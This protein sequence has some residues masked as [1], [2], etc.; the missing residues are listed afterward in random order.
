[1]PAEVET[2]VLIV[3]AGVAGALLA[4]KLAQDGVKVTI[5]EAGG[6][7]DR[8][9]AVQR[10]L[11]AVAMVPEAPYAPQ[12]WAPSPNSVDIGQY[13]IQEGPQP[14]KST[15]ERRV[16]G[17]TWHW[18]GTALR[19]VPAD[20]EL[21]KRY[22][23]GADWPIGYADLEPWY[24]EAEKSLGVSGDS[25]QDL[26]SPRKT[27]YPMP[28]IPQTTVDAA[29][30][31]AAR[32]LQLVVAP[33]PQAR[34]AQE[35]DGRPQCCGN[36]F[37]IPICPI[38]AKYDASA[39]VAQAEKAGVQVLAESVAFRV[40]IDS[41][42]RVTGVRFKKPDN[43][44]HLATARTYVVA[45]HAVETPRLLLMS[46]PKGVANSSDQVG[47]NLCDHPTQL[48]WALAA[49]P[50][51]PYRS[52]LATSGIEQL[53]DGA[54]RTSRGAF[55]VEIGNDG[56]SWPGM[57]PNGLVDSLIRQGLTGTALRER[58]DDNASRQFRFAS[59]VEQ[60]P[61]P[62][63]R[64]TLDSQLD[65]LGLPRPRIHYDVDGYT[66]AG[67]AEAQRLHDRLFDAM[68]ATDRAHSPAFEGAGHIIGTCRMGADPK[69]SV[70]DANSRTHDHAN[71][72]IIGSSVFP[73]TGTANPT[74]TIAAL[75]LRSAA[76][77]KATLQS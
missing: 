66:R 74:L 39:H 70:V 25:Q 61:D 27:P 71:L 59:L 20:F 72:F 38:G 53:R 43:S 75:A 16:G 19:L 9:A 46:S 77:V 14:F 15:Y 60:L 11:A 24:G 58:I 34:N 29:V 5:L 55:R 76:A 42:G 7:V 57:D 21:R 68:K 50:I 65:A 48:S 4:C 35:Y 73:S 62:Y 49:E 44:E 51:Y 36:A 45:A 13:Y 67:L 2:Q 41:G 10:A 54:F 17:T 6:R 37:C 32:T 33:T 40:E 69:T 63:N 8:A 30:S 3:G 12:A 26:G 31:K 18:L 56:W 22:G 52:P 23:V 1:M 64:V 47:R 28:A